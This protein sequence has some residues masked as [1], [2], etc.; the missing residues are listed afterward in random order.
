MAFSEL[1][2]KRHEKVIEAYLDTCRPP[3]EIRKEVDIWYRIK[4]QSIEVFEIRPKWNDP[5]EMQESP[6]AK[7]TYLK[8]RDEWKVYWMKSDLKWH[9]YEPTP[10]VKDLKTFTEVLELDQFGCFWG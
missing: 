6:V 2:Q 3:V 8:S 10:S 9:I 1:E 5:S 7:A 4:G